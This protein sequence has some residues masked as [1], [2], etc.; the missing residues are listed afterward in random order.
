LQHHGC[1]VNIDVD[2]VVQLTADCRCTHESC[3]CC[4]LPVHMP[5]MHM[6]P[7]HMPTCK[8]TALKDCR[9]KPCHYLPAN[10]LHSMLDRDMLS[11]VAWYLYGML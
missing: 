6:P 11:V 2:I 3:C 9:S 1:D 10:A 4:V 7:M 8:C 5:P